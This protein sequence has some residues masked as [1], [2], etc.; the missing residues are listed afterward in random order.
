[1]KTKK[2]VQ[3]IEH[4]ENAIVHEAKRRGVD[5]VICGRIDHPA[6]KQIDGVTY[7]KLSILLPRI[8]NA[9]YLD[10]RLILSFT[11]YFELPDT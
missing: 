5:G 11:S 10:R 6:M 9:A 7:A 2:A 4:Y 8:T 1:M 3:Y